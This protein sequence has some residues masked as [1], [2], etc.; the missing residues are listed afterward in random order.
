MGRYRRSGF[1]GQFGQPFRIS[2]RYGCV[3][4]TQKLAGEQHRLRLDELRFCGGC[5]RYPSGRPVAVDEWFRWSGNDSHPYRHTR[6]CRGHITHEDRGIVGRY[7]V[8]EY[9]DGIGFGCTATSVTHH[10]RDG[11]AL[12]TSRDHRSDYAVD[13]A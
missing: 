12:H 8:S 1:G 2:C 6:R 13:P 11:P 4:R 10:R 7:E 9:L 5:S 3:G